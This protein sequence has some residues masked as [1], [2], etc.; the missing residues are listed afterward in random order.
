MQAQ[1]VMSFII[2]QLDWLINWHF[3]EGNWGRLNIILVIAWLIIWIWDAQ[4]MLE[5]TNKTQI[6]NEVFQYRP[7]L[8]M[9][10]Q[11]QGNKEPYYFYQNSNTKIMRFQT[12]LSE[13]WRI[14][15]N[16]RTWKNFRGIILSSGN[17]WKNVSIWHG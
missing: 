12:N 8:S 4:W 13:T 1:R 17:K 14:K 10:T 6:L 11:S 7:L 3:R 5:Y 9:Q 2:N 16:N 15:I